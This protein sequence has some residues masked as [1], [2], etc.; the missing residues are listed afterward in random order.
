M[1]LDYA[2]AIVDIKRIAGRVKTLLDKAD[3]KRRFAGQAVDNAYRQLSLVQQ[4]LALL[5]KT[6]QEHVGEERP[7]AT[8]G[9][10]ETK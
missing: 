8:V 7:A 3:M 6:L 9:P 1:D 4:N 5:E 10:S 2:S